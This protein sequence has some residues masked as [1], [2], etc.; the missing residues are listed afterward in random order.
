MEKNEKVLRT[1]LA[2][3]FSLLAQKVRDG[4]MTSSEIRAI[5]SAVSAT[6]GVKAPVK[7]LAEFS[8]QSED[9][10]RHVIHRNFMPDPVRRVYYDFGAFNKIVPQKWRDPS[11]LPAD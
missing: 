8:G 5:L 9:N 2:D 7:D 6:G 1:L 10:I 11:T 3:M 4:E